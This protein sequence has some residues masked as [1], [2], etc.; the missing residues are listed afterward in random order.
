MMQVVIKSLLKILVA[1]PPVATFDICI[2]VL[3][4][5]PPPKVGEA[6]RFHI[7]TSDSSKSI[8]YKY[9]LMYSHMYHT[10]SID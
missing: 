10:Y 3:F 9:M 2:F 4:L 6:R 5:S 8:T 1:V 7:Q